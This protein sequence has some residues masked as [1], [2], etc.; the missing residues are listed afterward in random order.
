MAKLDRGI[1]VCLICI[2]V[3][4][5]LSGNANGSGMELQGLFWDKYADSGNGDCSLSGF[6]GR[7]MKGA[8]CPVSI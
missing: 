7:I 5:A 3:P 1:G 8:C 2:R 4:Y 6:F